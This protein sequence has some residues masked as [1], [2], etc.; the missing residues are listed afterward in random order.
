MSESG[1]RFGKKC[2]YAQRQVDEQPCKRS[3]KMVTKVQWPRSEHPA[4]H[5]LLIPLFQVSKGCSHPEFP[6]LI[7]S[8]AAVTDILIQNFTQCMGPTGSSTI[9]SLLNRRILPALKTIRLS[10]IEGH[11]KTRSYIQSIESRAT[12]QEADLDDEQNS[13]SVGFTTVLTGARSKCGTMQDYQSE[14]ELLVQFI[15]RF[16][17]YRETCRSVN[18]PE[19]DESRLFRQTNFPER[20]QHVFGSNEPSIRFSNPANVAKS[21][22]DRNKDHSLAEARSE[23]TKWEYKVESLNTCISE[24][25]DWDRHSDQ[26]FSRNERIE[27]S[28]RIAGWRNLFTEAERKSSNNTETHITSACFTRKTSFLSDSGEFQEKELQ[29]KI[30]SR[31][32]STSSH[33][34]SSF[35]AKPRLTLPTWYSEFVWTTGKRFLAAHA[36]RSIH[37]TTPGATGAVPVQGSTGTPVARGEERIGSTTTMPMS[38]RRPSTMNSFCQWKSNRI[39]WMDSKDYGYRSFS[40]INSALYHHVCVGR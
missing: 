2:S 36:L 28:S 35:Y 18:K 7:H 11:V 20:H 25:S 22:F 39:L 1:C 9:R 27:E 29:R 8:N 30:F 37:L 31:S 13:C 21:L 19:W 32:Q 26:K 24:L 12:P 16:D 38:E 15:S 40:L 23:P 33:P 6:A 4:L 3:Q 17:K 5:P 14:R 10:H 34:K